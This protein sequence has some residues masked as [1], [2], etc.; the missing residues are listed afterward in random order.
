MDRGLNSSTAKCTSKPY[1]VQRERRGI[2]AIK[3]LTFDIYRRFRQAKNLQRRDQRITK[4]VFAVYARYYRG[5]HAAEH[6][7]A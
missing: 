2:E 5:H 3:R 1:S 4:A 7:V 6:F